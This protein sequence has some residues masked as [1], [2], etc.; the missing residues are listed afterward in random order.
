MTLLLQ[1]LGPPFS[2]FQFFFP[3]VSVSLSIIFSFLFRRRPSRVSA[4]GLFSLC[5]R[6]SSSRR[7]PMHR[8]L[9]THTLGDACTHRGLLLFSSIKGIRTGIA[10]LRK[11][12]SSRIKNGGT[13]RKGKNKEVDSQYIY[14]YAREREGNR[15]C[16]DP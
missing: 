7:A 1:R 13:G 3:L 15:P 14:G 5:F 4:L 16:A 11:S 8:R 9:V 2:L 6:P 10:G 12:D